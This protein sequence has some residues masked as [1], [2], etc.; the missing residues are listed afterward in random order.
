MD[1]ANKP[2]DDHAAPN[3]QTG[4]PTDRLHQDILRMGTLVEEALR[5]GLSA[6]EMKDYALAD[7][8]V[9]ADRNIDQMQRAIEQQCTR[10]IAEEHP[11][12]ARLREI[13]TAIKIATTLERLGDHARHLARRARSI[14]DSHY[15][16]TLPIIREMAEIGISMLHDLLTAWVE[17][18]PDRA[19]SVAARDDQLDRL[20]AQL[21]GDIVRIIQ[22]R[23][24]TIERGVDLLFVN[25][26]LERLGDHVTNM[27]EWVVF[28]ER[29]EY[30]ELNQ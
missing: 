11:T 29:A 6:L 15:I 14:T 1:Q 23:P 17:Q 2:Y 7:H 25:R 20:H 8:V 3:R 13:V 19:I 4:G 24:D 21:M 12:G 30:V 5:K 28:V 26:F 9:A 22:A 10:L 27:C 16:Q 18:N